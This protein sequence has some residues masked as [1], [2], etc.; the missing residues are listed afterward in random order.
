MSAV[1]VHTQ[2]SSHMWLTSEEAGDDVQRKKNPSKLEHQPSWKGHGMNLQWPE[3]VG[4]Q[5]QSCMSIFSQGV[6]PIGP[7]S[8]TNQLPFS[9]NEFRENRCWLPR[10]E[11]KMTNL[12]WLSELLRMRLQRFIFSVTLPCWKTN[13]EKHW[14]VSPVLPVRT[15]RFTLWLIGPGKTLANHWEASCW[16]DVPEIEGKLGLYIQ[17]PPM[18]WCR[19]TINP[20]DFG[21]ISPWHSSLSGFSIPLTLAHHFYSLFF[22]AF[23]EMLTPLGL[24][25]LVSFA[26]TRCRMGF[27]RFPRHFAS[28]SAVS[29]QLQTT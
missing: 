5:F 27:C 17:R 1:P 14:E 21:N 4:G 11:T 16:F 6:I 18:S 22:N 20:G 23:K 15:T 25:Q 26:L 13:R 24:S 3:A 12:K 2:A 19:G 9:C 7:H 28:S 8:T 29:P 10:D